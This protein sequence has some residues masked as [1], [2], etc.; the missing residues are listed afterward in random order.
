MNTLAH[1]QRVS[2]YTLLTFFLLASVPSYGQ[3]VNQLTMSTFSGYSTIDATPGKVVL[4][5]P[6]GA[7]SGQYSFS[8]PFAFKYDDQLFNAG[9]TLYVQL[10]G[11][12][13][14]VSNTGSS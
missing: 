1:K 4:V 14:F 3:R 13:S 8:M 2:L 7:I 10:A 5:S 9:A 11:S 12:A 6:S